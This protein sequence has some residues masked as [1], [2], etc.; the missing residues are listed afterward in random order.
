VKLIHADRDRNYSTVRRRSKTHIDPPSGG[1]DIFPAGR[2]LSG[3]SEDVVLP[4][5]C[6]IPRS[7]RLHAGAGGKGVILTA[8]GCRRH[9]HPFIADSPALIV[10]NFR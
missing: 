8:K 2:Y 9:T 7:A 6:V 10:L 1:V 5:K 3:R 4:T